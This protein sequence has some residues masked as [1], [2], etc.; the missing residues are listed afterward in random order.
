MAPGGPYPYPLLTDRVEK[1]PATFSQQAIAGRRRAS[2]CAKLFAD[3]TGIGAAKVAVEYAA[4]CCRVPGKFKVAYEFGGFR[5]DVSNRILLREGKVVPLPPKAF[6]TLVLLVRRRDEVLDK[7]EMMRAL[8][9][10][11]NVEESN[12][13]QQIF[14]LRKT[15]ADTGTGAQFIETVPRRG[16]HFIGEVTECKLEST[17]EAGMRSAP[18]VERAATYHSKLQTAA[19]VALLSAAAAAILYFAFR[20]IRSSAANNRPI[21]SIAVLPLENLTGEA[22]QQYYVD[23]VT[24]AVTEELGRIGSLHVIS[25]A[26]AMRYRG[27]HKTAR[28]IGRELHVDGLVEGTVERRGDRLRVN[29]E[30]LDARSGAHIWAQ[31]Y[32]RDV[33]DV[34]KLQSQLA[35]NIAGQVAVNVSARQRQAMAEKPAVDLVAQ[36]AYLKGRFVWNERTEHAYLQAIQLFDEALSHDPAYAAAYAGLADSYA[37]LGSLPSR[38]I[39]RSDAMEKARAAA[40]RAIQLDPTLA[41]A[42]TSLA[43]VLM[44]YDWKFAEAEK[45]FQLALQ[46]DPSYATA[47]QWYAYDLM[48]MGR[49]QESLEE[50]QKAQESDPLSLIIA[51]DRGE[52]LRY[53]GE[54]AK[55][56]RQVNEVTTLDPSFPLAHN[57]LALTYAESG[58]R[59]RALEEAGRFLEL[60]QGEMAPRFVRA[61]VAAKAGQRQLAKQ[62]LSHLTQEAVRTGSCYNV[63]EVYMALNDADHVFAWLQRGLNQREGSLILLRVDPTWR[64]L[65]SDSRFRALVKRIGFP[66]GS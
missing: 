10:D 3:K 6:D 55:A 20:S 16:Y 8:W 52:L 39:T 63:A 2:A 40:N 31:S 22:S 7:Q 62:I 1:L 32:E 43:F 12:L 19:T 4:I 37:L 9:G 45:E 47:H 26:S 56:V 11:L 5:L 66:T 50:N 13:T 33:R 18:A 25:R 49:I 54:D 36:E 27:S 23:G 24:D 28:Q 48:A 61:F 42:H 57:F 34:M 44:H 14:V 30:L 51:T 58:D 15:L 53:A 17:V 35:A 38:A 59:G 29:A 60:A 21:R 41:E 46:F 64:P 65:H